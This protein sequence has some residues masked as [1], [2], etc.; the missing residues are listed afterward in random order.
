MTASDG[1]RKKIVTMK[2]NKN[3][4]KQEA[5]NEKWG[6]RKTRQKAFTEK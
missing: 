3:M 2:K 1:L 4:K 5:P 6:S